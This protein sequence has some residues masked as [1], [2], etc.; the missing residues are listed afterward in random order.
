MNWTKFRNKNIFNDIYDS[1]NRLSDTRSLSNVVGPMLHLNNTKIVGQ[2]DQRYLVLYS[3]AYSSNDH[4][5]AIICK[6]EI[7]RNIILYN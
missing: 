1:P 6:Y 7:I 3:L 2:R 5:Y 4:M